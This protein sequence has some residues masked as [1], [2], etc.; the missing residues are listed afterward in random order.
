MAKHFGL[1]RKFLTVPTQVPLKS[2]YVYTCSNF[3]ATLV[4][5]NKV[6]WKLLRVCLP[7]LMC[8][9]INWFELPAISIPSSLDVDHW[10][11]YNLWTGV[12]PNPIPWGHHSRQAGT[13]LLCHCI[14]VISEHDS[15]SWIMWEMS[16][17]TCTHTSPLTHTHYFNCSL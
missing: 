2:C 11:S 16:H 17:S 14:L 4:D 15:K 10:H 6:A 1:S 7:S 13:P 8:M 12:V 9:S 3:Q 5:F